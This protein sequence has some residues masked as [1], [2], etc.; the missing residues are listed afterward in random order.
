MAFSENL[1]FN[2][3][4]CIMH[5]I[6]FQKKLGVLTRNLMVHFQKY[7]PHCY[8]FIQLVRE[9]SQNV[10]NLADIS[11]SLE[12]TLFENWC[13]LWICHVV[14]QDTDQTRPQSSGQLYHSNQ[15]DTLSCSA[16]TKAFCPKR[17]HNVRLNGKDW[18]IRLDNKLKK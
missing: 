14:Y 1:D 4:A 16:R 9:N 13:T 5:I 7:G 10:S 17:V 12:S 15:L 3:E 8:L 2:S 11:Y 6:I 18:K